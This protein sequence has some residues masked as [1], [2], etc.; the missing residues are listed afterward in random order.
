MLD[1]ELERRAPAREIEVRVAPGVKLG[2]AAQGLAAAGGGGA[3]LGVVDEEDGEVVETVELAQEGEQGGD[4][5]GG[6]LVDAVQSHERVEHQEARTTTG[7][8]VAQTLAMRGEIE[9]HDRRGDDVDVELLEHAAAS[10]GDALEALTHDVLGV[11][12]GEKQDAAG[13]G[14]GEAT[15]A[16]PSG[17]DGHGDVEG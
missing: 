12:G 3:L 15:Q 14:H 2:G 16:R 11:L 10:E 4:V 5:A 9:S 8:R 13:S 6:V 1:D 7:D 17:G